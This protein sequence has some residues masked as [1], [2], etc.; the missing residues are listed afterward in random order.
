MIREHADAVE[1]DLAYRGIDFR[2]HFRPGGGS[3]RLTLRRLA[4]LL[5]YLPRE[6]HTARAQ[7]GDGFSQSDLLLMEIGHAGPLSW[8]HPFHE[9]ERVKA[10]DKARLIKERAAYHAARS[11]ELTEDSAP[12]D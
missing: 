10:T 7:G 4:V 11:A 12:A 5:R 8:R 3:S 9:S 6:S 2:D 1:A